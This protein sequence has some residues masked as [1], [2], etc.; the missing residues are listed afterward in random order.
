MLEQT[1]PHG[2]SLLNR[3]PGRRAAPPHPH[4]GRRPAAEPYISLGLLRSEHRKSRQFARRLR[5]HRS[6]QPLPH[7][8]Q[9]RA[10][11]FL[12]SCV[13][14]HQD[15][16]RAGEVQRPGRHPLPVGTSRSPTLSLRGSGEAPE[17]ASH[18]VLWSGRGVRQRLTANSGIDF[19]L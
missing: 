7:P 4:M 6:A 2:S 11:R 8:K 17:R 9:S 13:G 15:R 14:H 10:P 18:W 3:D 19:K 5:N 16:R 12:G 1:R